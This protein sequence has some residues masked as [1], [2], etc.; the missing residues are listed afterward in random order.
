M[1]DFESRNHMAVMAR[2]ITLT[3]R[4][5]ESKEKLLIPLRTPEF[6]LRFITVV[7]GFIGLFFILCE[8]E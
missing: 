5:V 2:S 7:I 8:T 4:S 3:F 6:Y 1:E